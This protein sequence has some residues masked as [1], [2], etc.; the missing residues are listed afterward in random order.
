MTESEVRQKVV[1]MV[2]QYF[3]CNEADGSH[4]KIIENY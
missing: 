3:C 1:N 4:R 2:I